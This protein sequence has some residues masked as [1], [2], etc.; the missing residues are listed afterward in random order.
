MPESFRRCVLVADEVPVKVPVGLIA[1]QGGHLR[2]RRCPGS[3]QLLG[4]LES[5]AMDVLGEG[6]AAFPSKEGR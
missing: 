5:D 1:D 6:A 3:N 2:E 4:S